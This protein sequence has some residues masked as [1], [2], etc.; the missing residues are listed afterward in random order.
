[1]NTQQHCDALYLYSQRIPACNTCS[2]GDYSSLDILLIDVCHD[3]AQANNMPG[4]FL[5]HKNFSIPPNKRLPIKPSYM[6]QIISTICT[7]F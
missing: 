3:I 1:M 6:G 5:N 2:Q 7:N 4:Y